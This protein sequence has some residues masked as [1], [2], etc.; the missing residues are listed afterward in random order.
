MRP[1]VGRG[2]ENDLRVRDVDVERGA[3][4]IHRA[5]A[6]VAREYVEGLPKSWEWRDVPM[7]ASLMLRLMASL[8]MIPT[9]PYS[10]SRTGAR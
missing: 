7:P 9:C 3:L 4:H 8:P 2:E 6:E 5:I 10:R 1:A